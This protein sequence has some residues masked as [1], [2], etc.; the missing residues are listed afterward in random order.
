MSEIK[1]DA[2]SRYDQIEL[3]ISKEERSSEWSS[4]LS[5]YLNI[6]FLYMVDF[7][8]NNP[9]MVLVNIVVY[10]LMYNQMIDN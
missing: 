9:D 3:V 4:S 2:A 6:D 7:P 10:V 1:L 5:S 8:L